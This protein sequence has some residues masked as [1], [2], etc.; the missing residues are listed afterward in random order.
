MSSVPPPGQPPADVAAHATIR[1]LVLLSAPLVLGM[2]AQSL[3]HFTDRLFIARLGLEATAAG[4]TAGMLAW[5]CQCLFIAACGFSV[6]IAAQHRGAGEPGKVGPGMWP[7]L[8]MAVIGGVVCALLIPL[9]PI[10]VM[11]MRL[12][13]GVRQG[14]ITLTACFLAAAVPG[15]ITAAIGGFFAGTGRTRMVLVLNGLLLAVNALLQWVLIFGHAGLPALGLLGS[16][17][18]TVVA[19]LVVASVAVVLFLRRGERRDWATGIGWR[20]DLGRFRRFAGFALPQSGRQL[21]EMLVWTGWVAV[22]GRFGSESLAANNVLLTWNVI[23]MMPMAGMSQAVAVAVGAASGAGRPDLARLAFGRGI[24]LMGGFAVAVA[25]VV[26]TSA[27]MLMA[28]F[29][30]DSPE[31]HIADVVRIA[32]QLVPVCALYVVFDAVNLAYSGALSGAG[33]TRYQFKV[34]IYGLIPS[35]VIPVSIVLWLGRDWWLARGI[36]PAAAAWGASVF[37]LVV[38]AL[39]LAARWHRG[40][41]EGMGAQLRADAG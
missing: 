2:A 33:D 30:V 32:H 19:N 3:I 4:F 29:L 23:A 16:G 10:L 8:W 41:W 24:G 21:A 22:V 28:P 36:E 18:G 7:A 27:D 37:C 15:G 17:M 13:P 14:V 5:T 35:L 25:V 40:G 26:L 34:V 1:G 31:V 39:L 9:L 11:P 20:P 38:L 6:T 12:A